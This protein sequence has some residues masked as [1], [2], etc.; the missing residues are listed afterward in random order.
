MSQSAV[1][2]IA[3]NVNVGVEEEAEN[4]TQLRMKQ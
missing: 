4:E 2:K 1:H 3:L